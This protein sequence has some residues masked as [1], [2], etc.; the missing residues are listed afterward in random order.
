MVL[1]STGI[2]RMTIYSVLYSHIH[3]K[4]D[5]WHEFA[6]AGNVLGGVLPKVILPF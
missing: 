2:A 3:S 6:G 5:F 4:Y 1:C